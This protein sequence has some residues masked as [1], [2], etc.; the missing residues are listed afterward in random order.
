MGN[1]LIAFLL[2]A[3][4]VFLAPAVPAS[5]TEEGAAPAAGPALQ[6][7]LAQGQSYGGG[8]GP[9]KRDCGRRCENEQVNCQRG[10]F[11]LPERA[12]QNECS[13][14]CIET[15]LECANQCD[16]RTASLTDSALWPQAW[17]AAAS[18]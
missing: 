16:A 18:P 12:A 11:A 4:L 2:A 10:C 8:S 7:L 13:V 17:F 14:Q 1:Q 3:L 5:D 15:Y 9:R 6:L